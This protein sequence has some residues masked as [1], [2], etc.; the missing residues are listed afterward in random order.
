MGYSMQKSVPLAVSCAAVIRRHRCLC[1]LL[2]PCF[3][4]PAAWPVL[5]QPKVSVP[6]VGRCPPPRQLSRCR[7]CLALPS[8]APALLGVGSRRSAY[9]MAGRLSIY[10]PS[11]ATSIVGDTPLPGNSTCWQGR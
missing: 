8:P 11:H 4:R 5:P 9:L 3:G 10:I 2:L 7:S 1:L 6:A